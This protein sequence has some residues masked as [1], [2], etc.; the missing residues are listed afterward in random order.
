MKRKSKTKKTNTYTSVLIRKCVRL[1]LHYTLD[2]SHKLP[3]LPA[4]RQERAHSR[5]R[6][7][8][9]LRH[10]RCRRHLRARQRADGQYRGCFASVNSLLRH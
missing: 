8:Q 3:V 6:Q 7:Q 9:R 10:R 1:H 4:S 5:H 2:T